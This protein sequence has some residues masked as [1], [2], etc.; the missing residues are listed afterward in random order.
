MASLAA[1]RTTFVYR[2]TIN[3]CYNDGYGG[4][5]YRKRD[6]DSVTLQKRGYV[7]TFAY[8]D[9][10]SATAGISALIMYVCPPAPHKALSALAT[11]FS[12]VEFRSRKTVAKT[13]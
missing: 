12:L 13:D 3:G 10:M 11:P 4:I 8:L 2:T 9:M 1:L 6:L 7:A 5:C